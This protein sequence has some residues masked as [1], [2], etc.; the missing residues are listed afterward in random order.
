MT[1]RSNG[2]DVVDDD[3]LYIIGA[4]CHKS[5]YFQSWNILCQADDLYNGGVS[6]SRNRPRLLAPH[7][8]A[9]H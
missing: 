7:S 6:V 9:I 2:D 8:A 3:D 1:T 5:H 4:V